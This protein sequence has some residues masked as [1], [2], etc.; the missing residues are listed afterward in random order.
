MYLCFLCLLLELS[1][2]GHDFLE[3]PKGDENP[4][5]SRFGRGSVGNGYFLAFDITFQG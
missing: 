3:N 2:L 1:G 4:K 5:E